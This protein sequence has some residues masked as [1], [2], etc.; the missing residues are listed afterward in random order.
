MSDDNEYIVFDKVKDVLNWHE[1]APKEKH[2][3]MYSHDLLL[4]CHKIEDVCQTLCLARICLEDLSAKNFGELIDEHNE[5]S[6]TLMKYIFL[7]SSISYYN[8]CIDL[9]WQVLWI[10]YNPLEIKYLAHDRE[11]YEKSTKEC[12]L[13]GTKYR[14]ALA[15]EKKIIPLIDDFFGRENTKYIRQK[16]NYTK[17]RGVYHIDGLGMNYK[18]SMISYSG[19]NLPLIHR[20][21]LDVNEM[22]DNLIKFDNSFV[23]YFETI[24]SYIVPKDFKERKP[25][26]M[27]DMA[28]Y[29]CRYAL[30]HNKS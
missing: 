6:I 29:G 18:Q 17:H 25:F 21:E 11:Y 4:A 2:Y 27:N 20:E 3:H 9:S 13:E 23:Q 22:I 15:Q 28:L 1:Y 19:I 14:L 30:E 8:Y 24:I 26:S 5:L 7:N 12:T 10:Y 16:Y